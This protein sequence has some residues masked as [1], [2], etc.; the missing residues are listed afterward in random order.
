MSAKERRKEVTPFSHA[1]NGKA[2]SIRRAQGH[3]G[4]YSSNH[5]LWFTLQLC[6]SARVSLAFFD[7]AEAEESADFSRIA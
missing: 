4:A 3:P 7:I 6:G 2:R 5:R 1:A